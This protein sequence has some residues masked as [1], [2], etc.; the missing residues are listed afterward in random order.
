MGDWAGR[1]VLVTGASGFVGSHLAERLV[2]EGARVRALVRDPNKLI[3]SLK[4]RVEVVTGDLLQSDGFGRATTGCEVVFHVAGQMGISSPRQISYAVNVVATRQLAEAAR[5]NGVIRFIATSSIAVYGPLTTG[6]VDE[7]QPH[8]PVYVYAETK[9]LGEQAALVIGTDRFGVTIIRPGMIYGPRGRAWTTLPVRL[10]RRGWPSLIGGGHGLCHPV[11]VENLIDAYL[12]AAA[13]DAAIG[14][15]FTVVD[16]DVEWREFFGRYAA[17]AGRR[18]WSLPATV[19]WL[20]ALA[21]E[22]AAKLTRR[23][24]SVS[25][26]QLK[27][28]TGRCRFNT[29]KAR[30]LLGWSPKYSLAEGLQQTEAW[31]RQA[32]YLTNEQRLAA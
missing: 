16:D 18:A 6:L 23:T 14:E 19:V 20:A 30:R 21:A 5:S 15:A 32:G 1:T 4:E 29:D 24:P 12:L 7:S 8:W 31:L 9:S 22:F 28:V 26:L 10:A 27:F 3:D 2:N 13:H 17:M 11:Y 25:R